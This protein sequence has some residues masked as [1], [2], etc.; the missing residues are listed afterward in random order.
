MDAGQLSYGWQARRLPGGCL[1][2]TKFIYRDE[3]AAWAE[4]A[5]D[6]GRYRCVLDR[7]R[8]AAFGE[9]DWCFSKNKAHANGLAYMETPRSNPKQSKQFSSGSGG[10]PS[11]QPQPERDGGS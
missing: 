4:A 6:E 1:C 3:G 11:P 5:A 10:R 7:P 8:G 2:T 9:L